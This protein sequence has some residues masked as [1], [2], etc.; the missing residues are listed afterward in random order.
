MPKSELHNGQVAE[1]P[2]SVGDRWCT[3][4]MLLL[5]GSPARRHVRECGMRVL[6][7]AAGVCVT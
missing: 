5:T 3:V 1:T 4:A 7:R 6:E 2:H